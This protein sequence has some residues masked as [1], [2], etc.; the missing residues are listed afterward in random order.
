MNGCSCGEGLE[1]LLTGQLGNVRHGVLF[2]VIQN[3]GGHDR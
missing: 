2:S 3:T 1:L